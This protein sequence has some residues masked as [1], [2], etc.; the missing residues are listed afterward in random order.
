M[1]ISEI[2]LGDS[3][4]ATK[5]KKFNE[6]MGFVNSCNVDVSIMNKINQFCIIT[7][8]QRKKLPYYLSINFYTFR[9]TR[10]V[11]TEKFILDK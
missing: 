1:E 6:V 3:V 5:G 2:S 10:L 11:L 4:Y 9:T 7:T 8:T